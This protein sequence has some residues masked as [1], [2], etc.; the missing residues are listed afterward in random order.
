MLGTSRVIT[1]NAGVVCY[2]ADFTP[3]GGYNNS[4]FL[5][6]GSNDPVGGRST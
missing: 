6:E 1:S 3:F 2:D 5:L 4:A